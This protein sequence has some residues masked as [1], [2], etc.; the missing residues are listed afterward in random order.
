M[1]IDC[2]R[3]ILD[4]RGP[5]GISIPNTENPWLKNL[6]AHEPHWP[7]TFHMHDHWFSWLSIDHKNNTCSIFRIHDQW[8]ASIRHLRQPY[9]ILTYMLFNH[10]PWSILAIHHPS[11]LRMMNLGGNPWSVWALHDPHS[12]YK[13]H[14]GYFSMFHIADPW[15]TF[16][17]HDPHSS[18]TIHAEETRDGR[19]GGRE[20]KRA[21]GRADKPTDRRAD[22]WTYGHSD[23]LTGGRT[24][25]QPQG[26]TDGR[27]GRG[28]R[29]PRKKKTGKNEVQK[30]S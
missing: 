11:P 5:H 21:S 30:T 16:N 4:V 23:G 25:G 13:I 29:P 17:I 6:C 3:S 27:T 19:A 10:N 22:G 9:S 8:Q 7:S 12:L 26:R 28:N 20:N 18:S 2:T 1:D 15:L 24:G 14:Y